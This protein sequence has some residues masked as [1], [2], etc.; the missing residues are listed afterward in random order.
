MTTDPRTVS[1]VVHVLRHLAGE[2]ARE[3][4][5]LAH[6]AADCADVL[7]APEPEDG[8]RLCGA[9]LPPPAPTGRPRSRCLRCS[10]PRRKRA[11]KGTVAE[12][13]TKEVVMARDNGCACR[14]PLN[15]AP[16]PGFPGTEDALK[17]L[18]DRGI[19]VRNDYKGR[20]SIPVAAAQQLHDEL[21]GRAAAELEERHKRM[22]AVANAQR[23]VQRLY[24]D[25]YIATR[26]QNHGADVRVAH[27]AG[28]AAVGEYTRT[29][30]D[31]VASQL[32]LRNSVPVVV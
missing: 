9:P 7:A 1:N 24:D 28:M 14:V 11:A 18:A 22:A 5:G 12:M 19:E 30:P 16:V 23:E 17:W 21:A 31:D 25:V 32:S 27:V 20:L 3:R 10:P 13:T 15:E 26:K 2:L 8:C 6:L 4:H 29:L